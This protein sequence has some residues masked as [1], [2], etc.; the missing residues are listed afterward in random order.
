M[1]KSNRWFITNSIIT[2]W[3]L[4]H[5]PLIAITWIRYLEMNAF[6]TVCLF[7][8][9]FIS[10]IQLWKAVNWARLT[11]GVIFLL[12]YVGLWAV[13]YDIGYYGFLMLGLHTSVVLLIIVSYITLSLPMFYM[14]FLDSKYRKFYKSKP[15][16]N[17]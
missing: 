11:I 12:P 7:V 3:Y 16:G 2:L 5:I 6:S 8:F 4:L 10:L 9:L 17:D 15:K 13:L 14:I 1:M